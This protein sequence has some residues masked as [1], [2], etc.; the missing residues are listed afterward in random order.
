MTFP[1]IRMLG[2]TEG[3]TFLRRLVINHKDCSKIYF[4]M[5]TTLPIEFHS[6]RTTCLS[7]I[8][9]HLI[10]DLSTKAPYNFTI[11]F[12]SYPKPSWV[13]FTCGAY[14][15]STMWNISG[16]FDHY[17]FSQTISN[18]ISFRQCLNGLRT[19]ENG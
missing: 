3:I 14:R 16:P 10:T 15:K 5:L 12:L 7:N 2:I 17:K 9:R 18:F 4:W 19:N 8:L 11:S 6:F 13:K 1:S